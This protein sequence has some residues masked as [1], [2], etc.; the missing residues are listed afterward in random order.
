MH[1]LKST[2][3]LYDSVSF[4]KSIELCCCHQNQDTEQL[5][6]TFKKFPHAVPLKSNPPKTLILGNY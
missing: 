2:F 1:I 3:Y 6:I 4:E 5:I